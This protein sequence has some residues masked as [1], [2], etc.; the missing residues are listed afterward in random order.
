M[1][2]SIL[3]ENL[4]L[5]K[6]VYQQDPYYGYNASLYE[7]SNV[8]DGLKSD[9]SY[10]GG[11]CMYS[12]GR[13]TAI[14]WVNLTGILSIHHVTIHYMTLNAP[15]GMPLIINIVCEIILKHLE[16][17]FDIDTF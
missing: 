6:P 2:F 13:Q 17:H 4:A 3:K 16:V 5:K 11:Q 1:N 14:W 15:W 7:A 10:S 9:L 12:G 8:V